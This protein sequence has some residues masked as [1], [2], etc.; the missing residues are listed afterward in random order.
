MKHMSVQ[1]FRKRGQ[2][3]V[4]CLGS[5]ALLLSLPQI[6]WAQSDI[7][8]IGVVRGNPSANIDSFDIEP[9]YKGKSIR[10]QGVI[11][12]R[13]LWKST[14]SDK[15]NHAFLIQNLSRHSDQN[16]AT[17]DGLFVYTGK[18]S[19]PRMNGTDDYVPTVGDWV[20]IQGLVGHRYGQTELS[21]PR[22]VRVLR[23]A[24]DVAK[25][26]PRIDLDSRIQD[27]MPHS[28]R[29][30]ESLEGMHVILKSGAVAQSGRKIVGQGQD[31]L[32][33]VIPAEHKVTRR[34][35]AYHNRVFRDA[36]PLDDLPDQ[37][38]D[39][40]NGFRILLGSLGIKGRHQNLDLMLPPARSGDLFKNEV[41]GGV[42]YSYGNY[43]FMPD[44]TPRIQKGADPSLNLVPNVKKSNKGHFRVVSYNMEN[45][46]DH[47]DD[48]SDP[49]D[50][51]E[52]SGIGSIRPPFNYLPKNES[53]YRNRL[54]GFAR[55]IVQDMESPEILLLQ[56]IEDQ[57]ILSFSKGKV[58][59]ANF[60]PDGLP[61]VLQEL[62][63][64]I[65]LKGGPHYEGVLNRAG[66]DERGI[67]CAFLFRTDRVSLEAMG[68]SGIWMGHIQRLFPKLA[69]RGTSSSPQPL[70]IQSIRPRSRENDDWVYPRASQLARFRIISSNAL[71]V[72]D[73]VELVVLNNHFSS[74]PQDRV[75][76][77][78]DQASLAAA[79]VSSLQKSFSDLNIVVAGD[80]NVFPRPD[81]PH[82]KGPSDQLRAL[83]DAGM[84]N[85][86]GWVLENEPANAYSYVYE[87]QAQ[88]LDHCFISKPLS[89]ALVHA[90]FLHINADWPGLLR[91][92]IAPNLE[93]RGMSDHDPLVLSFDMR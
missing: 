65:R 9:A 24:F 75:A 31:A 46:Y 83:Y 79:V 4:V 72:E 13:L 22:L 57:D 85:A 90:F 69:V 2:V 76:L 54:E 41:S 91:H 86:Y 47:R 29:V 81:D 60:N 17:S 14:Q 15:P 70:A 64:A 58:I 37:R 16:P 35:Q 49:C 59:R 51:F 1:R 88:V 52:D 73:L 68:D 44:V 82:P 23:R 56:E 89:E 11:H 21:I 48:P 20:Q 87:G 30:F 18:E 25:V 12:Q 26:L 45:L 50:A 43:K 42:M 32:F 62:A 36:H 27:E 66:A 71:S 34:N 38:F 28:M 8:P 3:K 74:R 53:E 7:L 55:Q 39:N 40:G 93:A 84:H 6:L 19:V 80:L 33:W 77:R 92:K 78:R 61:D 67:A 10:I 63:Q 5:L